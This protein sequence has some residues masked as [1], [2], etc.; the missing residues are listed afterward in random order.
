MFCVVCSSSINYHR[1]L[2]KSHHTLHIKFTNYGD[3]F[4]PPK[5]TSRLASGYLLYCQ[6]DFEIKPG[7][8]KLL[9]LGFKIKSIC[10]IHVGWK[11]EINNEY[12]LRGLMV[13]G[14]SIDQD[15]Y[16]EVEVVVHNLNR[17]GPILKITRGETAVKLVPYML[18]PPEWFTLVRYIPPTPPRESTKQSHLLT[19]REQGMAFNHRTVV[20]EYVFEESY[21][22]RARREPS[23]PPVFD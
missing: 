6:S 11:V 23:P 5:L 8:T 10:D 4:I 1:Q 20:C 13:N 15:D 3:D 18:Y 14:G 19:E 17:D 22:H 12:A 21:V 2:M 7:E 16:N 9:G